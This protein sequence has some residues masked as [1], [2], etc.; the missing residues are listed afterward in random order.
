M[1][2]DEFVKLTGYNRCYTSY[3]LR[4]YEKK[5]VIYAK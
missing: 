4:M 2:P 5:I 3:V 1:I